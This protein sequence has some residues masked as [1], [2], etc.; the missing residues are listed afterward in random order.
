MPAFV[1]SSGFS[2]EY[3]VFGK[4]P[5]VLFAFHGFDNDANDFRIFEDSFGK[6][7]TIVA[8]NLFFH[9]K[10]DTPT[11]H[12]EDEFNTEILLELFNKLLFDLSCERFSFLGFSL[13]GRIILE[14]IPHYS[15]RINRVLLLAPD[16]L[17]IS[18]WYKFITGTSFG[19]KLFKRVVYKSRLT[20]QIAKGLNKIGVVKE[21]QYLFAL[22]NFDTLE[23]RKKVYNVW[24]IFRNIL[25][26]AKIV[27]EALNQYKIPVD[28]YFGKRDTIIPVG[29]GI[30]FIR[31]AVYPV[32]IHVL[33]AGHNLMKDRIVKEL[34]PWLEG[35]KKVSI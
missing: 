16:G 2:W 20:L 33:D 31:D 15:K 7:Y 18:K 23:K 24:M 35:K 21:K 3:F 25:P 19:K 9:G 22:S 17:K 26:Q 10:S 8:I 12:A 34:E 14:L 5:E 30:K 32:N 4:G 1:S 27:G 6:D 13:G 29:F 28:I 11:H